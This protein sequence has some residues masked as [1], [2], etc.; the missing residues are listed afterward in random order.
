[1][2]ISSPLHLCLLRAK[3]VLPK[4]PWCSKETRKQVLLEEAKPSWQGPSSLHTWGEERVCCK[5]LKLGGTC[6]SQHS[7]AGALGHLGEFSGHFDS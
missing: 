7:A 2:C 1:M 3:G 5:P 4:S 6:V